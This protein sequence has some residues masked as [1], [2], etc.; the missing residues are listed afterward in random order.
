MFGIRTQDGNNVDAYFESIPHALTACEL[1]M[2]QQH[3]R[4]KRV[5][6]EQE[7]LDALFKSCDSICYETD[8]TDD[9]GNAMLTPIGSVIDDDGTLAEVPIEKIFMVHIWKPFAREYLDVQYNIYR[10]T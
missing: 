8:A 6:I 5:D 10:T 9:D 7:N 4:I 3:G 1:D 2:T